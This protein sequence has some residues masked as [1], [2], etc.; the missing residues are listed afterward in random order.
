MRMAKGTDE[1]FENVLD[2]T[3]RIIYNLFYLIREDEKAFIA[4]DDATYIIGQKNEHAPLWIWL[5]EKPEGTNYKEICEILESRLEINHDLKVHAYEKHI[6]DILNNISQK[7]AINYTESMP[8]IVYACNNVTSI[9]NLSGQIIKPLEE[10]REI[11]K[12]FISDMVYDA[13]NIVMSQD[14]ASGFANSAVNSKNLYLWENNGRIV[15]M[16][17]IAHKTKEYARINTVFTDREQRGKG[18][19]GMLVSKISGI[20]LKEGIIPMLYA[21]SRNPASNFVYQK[22]GFEKY[23]EITKYMFSDKQY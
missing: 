17:M 23:G 22:I 14:D 16:A 4:T 2:K 6:T 3:D 9:N 20:L 11:L 21:D 1:V 5:R 19:A 8:M 13:E 12:R 15:S 18:Y 7:T 10:Y